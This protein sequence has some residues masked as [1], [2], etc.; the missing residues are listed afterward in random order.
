MAINC[1]CPNVDPSPTTPH[2]HHMAHRQKRSVRLRPTVLISS[3]V[4]TLSYNHFLIV[5]NDTETAA[6]KFDHPSHTLQAFIPPSTRPAYLALRALNIE[7]ARIGDT[8]SSPRIGELRLQFWRD[9][10]A[11]AFEGRPPKQPVTI[12]LASALQDLFQRAEIIGLPVNTSSLRTW[13]ASHVN[14]RA[15]RLYNP[16]Y[17]TLAEL[18]TYAE[19]TYSTLLYLTLSFLP[20]NSLTAD[21]LASHIG[22]AAGIAA[23]LR[24]VPLLAFPSPPNHHS[25]DPASIAMGGN[26]GSTQSAQRRAE[27]AIMLPL[28]IMARHSVHEEAIFRQG[29]EAPG[30]KDVVFEVATRASDHLLT[31]SSMLENL[32]RGQDV[33]HAFE[34]EE[35]EEFQGR[36]SGGGGGGGGK[37][38][39]VS[40]QLEEVERGFP[41]LMQAVGVRLWLDR[42]EA[43][44]FDVFDRGLRGGE[45]KLPWRAW[46]AWRRK[47]L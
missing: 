7:T 32:R 22:K 26:P 14:A 5:H 12:L 45:W 35:R 34:N 23:V 25:V 19:N 10:I 20:L 42:L 1:H 33:G 40:R 37:E 13:F 9:N 44:G 3:G 47:R 8:T 27:G 31:T 15:E 16:P 18:E 46:R 41:V 38:G 43:E 24:G 11:A 17:T 2:L 36:G 28:D 6:R 21:H 29:A 30:L 39:N 4:F